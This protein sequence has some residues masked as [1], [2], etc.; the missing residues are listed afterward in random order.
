MKNIPKQ[1]SESFLAALAEMSVSSGDARE[2]LKWLRFYLDS[3]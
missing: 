2:Q 3:E 1:L